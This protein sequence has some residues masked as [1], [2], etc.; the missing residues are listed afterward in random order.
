MDVKVKTVELPLG[1]PL[2]PQPSP[3]GPDRSLFPMSARFRLT[4][5]H[6]KIDS[7]HDYS[8]PPGTLCHLFAVWYARG[9]RTFTFGQLRRSIISVY[10]HLKRVR[11]SRC[12]VWSE[13]RRGLDEFLHWLLDFE[14][15]IDM[16]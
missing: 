7:V 1:L 11:S 3:Y 5:E 10:L 6:G 12:R 15:W 4:E 9:V 14:L 13:L 2:R 16:I 8:T